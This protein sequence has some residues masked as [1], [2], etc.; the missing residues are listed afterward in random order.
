[1]G[2]IAFLLNQFFVANAMAD[3]VAKVLDPQHPLYKMVGQ[4][5]NEKH[6]QE[7]GQG[8]FIGDDGCHILTNFHVAYGDG[9]DV[10]GEVKI[11]PNPSL[12]QR[13]TFSFN[14]DD[15]GKFRNIEKGKVIDFANYMRGAP[16]GRLGDL[17]LIRLDSCQGKSFA[18]LSWDSTTLE[19]GIPTGKLST[20]TAARTSNGKNIIVMET[21]CEAYQQTPVTGLILSTC[22]SEGGMSAN[23]IAVEGEDNVFRL[24]GIGAAL[25]SLPSGEKAAIG[26]SAK[27]IS[28]FVA[29]ILGKVPAEK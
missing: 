4:V 11:Q 25:G 15:T 19:K 28:K 10:M 24:A 8:F 22:H 14:P 3:S 12:G 23:L 7:F 2:S 20:I 29:T 27:V 16:R 18:G 13:I 5:N 1:M 17:A 26:I 6:P 9:A 21:G